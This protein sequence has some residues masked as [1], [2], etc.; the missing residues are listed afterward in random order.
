MRDT[1][2]SGVVAAA[3]A[4]IVLLLLVVG[5]GFYYVTERRQAELIAQVEMARAQEHQ[6]MMAEQARAKAEAALERLEA[7]TS[8]PPSPEQAD[9]IRTAVE[10]VFRAQQEAWNR[11]DID[12]FMEHYWKS[13]DLTFSSGGSTTRGWTATKANYKRR[14]PSRDAMGRLTFSDL[15]FFPLA[16]QAA[17]VLGRWRL[18]RDEPIGGNFSLVFRRIDGRW[19][20]VHDHT[21]VSPSE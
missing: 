13:D 2:A 3:I 9:A 15:E 20:I 19:L 18:M 11:G 7:A 21:S 16:D 4:L 17:L 14:Y 12:A 1:S 6:A 10:T 8:Q 5:A